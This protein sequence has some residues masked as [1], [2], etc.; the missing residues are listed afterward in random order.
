VGNRYLAVLRARLR[1]GDIWVDGSRAFCPLETQ[2]MPGSAFAARKA[3]SD[4]RLGVPNDA[5]AWITEKQRQLDFKLKKLGYQAR[6]GKLAGVR[7][8]GGVLT[9]AKHRTKVPKAKVE[10]AKWLILDHMPKIDITGLFGGGRCVDQ[11]CQFV[12]P[13]P[14]RRHGSVSAGVARGGPW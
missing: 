7:L 8:A 10:A 9:I 11:R 5:E 13:F 12:F 3:E 1:A 4:L 6:T 2:L 14:H